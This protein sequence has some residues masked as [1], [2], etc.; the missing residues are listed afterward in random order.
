M[1]FV[2]AKITSQIG[3]ALE[4]EI[5]EINYIG[6]RVSQDALLMHIN[7]LGYILSSTSIS[8]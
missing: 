2:M 4:T 5:N 8:T 6:P 3:C 1:Q 7:S